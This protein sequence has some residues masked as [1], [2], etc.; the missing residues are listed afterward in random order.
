MAHCADASLESDQHVHVLIA[1]FGSWCVE[2]FS[3]GG[4]ALIFLFINDRKS[5]PSRA[6]RFVDGHAVSCL[7]EFRNDAVVFVR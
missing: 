6:V 3:R 5:H 1:T 2:R 7:R 4:E